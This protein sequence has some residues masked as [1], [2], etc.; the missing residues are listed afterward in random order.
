VALGGDGRHALSGSD[1]RTVRWW[2][3]ETGA[4]RHVLQGHTGGVNAVALSGDGRHALSGSGDRTLRWWDLYNGSCIAR[5]SWDYRITALS[6]SPP[7]GDVP[8]RVVAGDEVGHVL[9]FEL[10]P[11]SGA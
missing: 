6:L 4:C 9:F 11:P 7:R 5:F 2:D 1:D 3:L 8:S 10:A